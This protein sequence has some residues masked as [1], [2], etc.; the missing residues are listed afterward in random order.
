MQLLPFYAIW[1]ISLCLVVSESTSHQYEKLSDQSLLWGAY[2]SNAYVGIRPRV[3]ETLLSG[4]MWYNADTVVGLSNTRHFCDQG[5]NLGKGFGWVKYDP[6][7]GGREVIHDEKECKIVLVVDFVKSKDGKNWALRV[8]G[9]PKKGYEK[10]KTSVVFYSGMEVFD[11]D[12]MGLNQYG[13]SQI[14]N[15][16]ELKSPVKNIGYELGEVVELKGYSEAL[17]GKFTIAVNDPPTNK[18]PHYQKV[19][20]REMDPA[21]THHLSLNF[22]GESIWQAKDIMWEMIKDNV[23]KLQE[24]F[25]DLY[26]ETPPDQLFALSNSNGFE[27]NLH[28]IQ[29]T[30]EGEFT[31]DIL[32]NVVETLD[33]ITFENLG[34]RVFD[35][36]TKV[37]RKFKDVFTLQAPFTT[38]KHWK[39]AQ[40]FFSN[41]I[42]GISYFH[43]DHLVD[44]TTVFDQESFNNVELKYPEKEGPFLLFTAVPSR[45]FFPRG[46]Y[47]DEGFHL[48]PI[49]EYDID[50]TLDILK[51]WFGLIDSDGWIARE[52]ILGTESRSKVPVEFQVQ[53]PNIA[54]PPTMMLCFTSLLEKVLSAGESPK[55]DGTTVD[56]QAINNTIL[57]DQLS[58]AHVHYP[59]LLVSY[60]EDIYPKLQKHYEW[61]RRTQRGI[62]DDFDREEI[63]D[64]DDNDDVYRWVGRTDTHCL[65]SGLDDYPRALPADIAELNVD[66]I[67]WIG[68][69]TRSMKYMAQLL[70]KQKDVA[71]Y[72][73]IEQHIVSNIDKLHWSEEEK[74]YCDM[75]VDDDDENIHV[76]HKGYIS[77]F[78]FLTRLIPESKVLNHKLK[79]V[80][81]MI[82][83]PEELWSPYG[84]RSLSKSDKMFKTGEDYWRSPIWMNINYM[85][86][87][88]L[89]YYHD[90]ESVQPYLEADVRELLRTVYY[91]LRVNL[92]TNVYNQ[93][94]KTGYGFENYNEENGDAQRVKHF[95]GWTSLVVL[96]MKM[97]ERLA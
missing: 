64:D 80:L 16:L 89:R 95:H 45:T 59:E 72:T 11:A 57:L 66:L 84:I 18:K 32:F 49:L 9:T 21:K 60:V 13:I 1:W 55:W 61:F 23:E 67:S 52:Q 46:F 19:V 36:L 5:D 51:S 62:S 4:L 29:K 30:F 14:E 93:W 83:N 88:S 77:L 39:F 87:D 35:V 40:E 78:P 96:M 79:H 54:N 2:R 3:P 41:L 33:Q 73:L 94:E 85:V 90:L 53:N 48:L 97:P 31:F 42:G 75:S 8:K 74:T 71:K 68:I 43:G 24:L 25:P 92:V 50:L 70:Q 12:K 22:P 20:S 65:P 38:K 34:K 76:C 28:F 37:D 27:G 26:Q 69:M 10:V 6:R 63:I 7:Y 44:R 47:W 86:L 91:E 56:Y 82:H 15:Y 58:E 81:E 17:G